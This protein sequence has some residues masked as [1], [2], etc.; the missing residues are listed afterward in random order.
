[1]IFFC[2]IGGG[3]GTM[4]SGLTGGSF[5]SVVRSNATGGGGTFFRITFL[6]STTATGT[7]S[8][9]TAAAGT[10]A[11]GTGFAGDLFFTIP[12]QLSKGLTM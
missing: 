2:V 10:T 5:L 4:T 9:T 11:T 3:G 7:G 12:I 8:G 6:F 1:M